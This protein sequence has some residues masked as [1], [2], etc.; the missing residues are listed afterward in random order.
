MIVPTTVLL[1]SSPLLFS[2]VAPRKRTSS[3]STIFPFS[4][5]RIAR[6]ASPSRA[7]P[8]S[9]PDCLTFWIMAAGSV[10]PQP[11]LIF[12]PSGEIPIG[13]TSA[14]SSLSNT[15]AI[16][17]PAPFAQSTTTVSPSRVNPSSR[18]DLAWTIYRPSASSIRRAL[19]SPMPSGPSISPVSISCS[20]SISA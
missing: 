6:S 7:I 14:P 8:T 10:E 20:R 5:Q 1:V 9:A 3:P 18:V 16:S 11:S 4:S 13:I 12:S 15:G 19:P 17:Y 2:R